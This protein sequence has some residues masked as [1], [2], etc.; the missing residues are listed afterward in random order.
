VPYY[1]PAADHAKQKKA[2]AIINAWAL[3][4]AELS[5]MKPRAI[6]MNCA[7]GSVIDRMVSVSSDSIAPL[8][9]VRRNAIVWPLYRAIV[10]RLSDESDANAMECDA[11]SYRVAR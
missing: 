4:A 9:R 5:M 1:W 11:N 6:L 10:A 3:D 2:L 8:S 7:R